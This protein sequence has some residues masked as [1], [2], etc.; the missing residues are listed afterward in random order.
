MMLDYAKNSRASWI[1]QSASMSGSVDQQND[2]KTLLSPNYFEVVEEATKLQDNA[3]NMAEKSEKADNV[4]APLPSGGSKVEDAG[5]PVKSKD[6]GEGDHG[7]SAKDHTPSD[8]IKVEPK[9]V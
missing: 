2:Q 6:G 8:N 3:E 7:E 1:L 5:S 4:D 9:K